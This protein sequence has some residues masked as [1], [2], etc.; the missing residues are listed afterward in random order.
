LAYG[1]WNE[2][3]D[4]LADAGQVHVGVLGHRSDDRPTQV[5]RVM[6]RAARRVLGRSRLLPPT[7]DMPGCDGPSHVFL[8]AR[9]PW[10]LPLLERLRPLRSREVSVSVWM[11]EVWPSELEDARL[12]YEAYSMVD[13]VFVGIDEAVEPFHSIAPK[14]EIHTLAPATDVLRFL[15]GQPDLARPIAV[16]GIGRRNPLQHSE[17]LAWAS[18]NDALY[19]YD[20]VKGSA[21]DWHQHRDAL[22][23]WYKNANIAVCNYA[24]HDVPAE[25][26]GLKVLPGRLFEGLASGA[27][28]IGMPPDEARQ[29][30][31]L[32]MTVV[33]PVEP[34]GRGLLELLDRF[35]DTA[36]ARPI[37]L[38]NLA[39][40]CR[41]HDWSHRWRSAFDAIGIKSPEGLQD[42][43]DY[44]DVKAAEFEGLAQAN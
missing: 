11:P 8:V 37:R 10:D 42:R 4:V 24:K 34:S 7:D 2:A 1:A 25:I 6:G 41:A 17:I 43:L 36:E 16:L 30:R 27:V 28:L 5:R 32:G 13:H 35:S 3:E 20:T 23:N 26:A 14:A 44:L 12:H 21:V 40:A 18:H 15:P 19:L 38:R 39:L 22:A 9:G 31:V 33:E 29:E